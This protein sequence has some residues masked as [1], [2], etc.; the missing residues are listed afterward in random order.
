M[1]ESSNTLTLDS[2]ADTLIK[3]GCY[4]LDVIYHRD[5]PLDKHIEAGNNEETP[6]MST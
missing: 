2:S 6:C 1:Q 3:N 4:V 5:N